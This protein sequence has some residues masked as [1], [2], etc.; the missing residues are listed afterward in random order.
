MLF[1][2]PPLS[3][4]FT[5]S[6]TPSPLERDVLYGRP[7]IGI[8]V[9]CFLFQLKVNLV[10]CWRDL[11]VPPF[12][13]WCQLMGLLH[14]WGLPLES[15]FFSVYILFQ[16]FQLNA[17]FLIAIVKQHLW[18]ILERCNINAYMTFIWKLSTISSDKFV[19]INFNLTSLS[20]TYVFACPYK[21]EPAPQKL[22]FKHFELRSFP[23]SH[24]P[25]NIWNM[26]KCSARLWRG[27]VQEQMK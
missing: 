24:L 7:H 20:V 18:N 12:E 11:Q 6:R 26:F 16:M 21:W 3:Q 14:A 2:P 13:Y 15:I 1:T 5:P 4:T 8:H 19:V 17:Q 25:R 27:H 9:T 22:G 10:T 23:K